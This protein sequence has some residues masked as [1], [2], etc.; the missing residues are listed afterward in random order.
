MS[1]PI[2]QIRD[3]VNLI[4]SESGYTVKNLNVSFPHPLD[5]KIIRDNKNNIILSFTESLPKVNWKKFITLTAWVQGLTLG[6][7]EGVLRL[8]YL[9]DIKFGYDQKSEDL[10]CQTYDFSDISEEISGE[11]QDPNSKKIADKCLHYA[12]EWATIASHNGTNF[13]ECNE[14]SRRQLKKDCKNFVMDNIKNDP[15]I[16]AGSVILTFLFFYVV[17]PMILKFILERL[18]KKLFSN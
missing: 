6:E 1:L 12:S 11:Y 4:F 13:A 8:K 18:F 16:V 9:P 17:L 5:I 2:Q 7:T 3:I 10:F 15:E 14:R